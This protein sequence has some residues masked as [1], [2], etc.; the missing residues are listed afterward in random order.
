MTYFHLL[1]LQ[2]TEKLKHGL[3][4]TIIQLFSF[5]RNWFF[6][7]MELFIPV[8]QI[9]LYFLYHQIHVSHMDNFVIYR[10]FYFLHG[11][12]IIQYIQ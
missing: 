9:H 2:S 6:R 7:G 5:S 11:A 1:S 8:S 10:L 3:L 12:V 4:H